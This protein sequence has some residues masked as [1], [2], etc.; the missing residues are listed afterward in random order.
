MKSDPTDPNSIT[1][2]QYKLIKKDLAARAAALKNVPRFRLKLFGEKASL[3]TKEKFR[4]VRAIQSKPPL[5][6]LT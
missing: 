6:I 3:L 2:E 1:E 4:Q 5:L